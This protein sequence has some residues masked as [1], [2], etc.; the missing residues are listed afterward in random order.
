MLQIVLLLC[1]S[2]CSCE[3]R[4]ASKVSAAIEDQ[5]DASIQTLTQISADSEVKLS[6]NDDFYFW[7]VKQA[8]VEDMP[9]RLEAIW[10]RIDSENVKKSLYSIFLWVTSDTSIS[11]QAYADWLTKLVDWYARYTG[12][13]LLLKDK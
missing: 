12:A 3:L 10:E 8:G 7:I 9:K 4:D 11:R 5:I 13:N 6:K 2:V 1:L